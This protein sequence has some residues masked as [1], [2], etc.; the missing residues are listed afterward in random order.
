MIDVG[1]SLSEVC[2]PGRVVLI[3]ELND[4]GVTMVTWN[5]SETLQVWVPALDPSNWTEVKIRTI[6]G[7][8]EGGLTFKEA[9]HHARVFLNQWM[10][11]KC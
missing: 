4:A 2:S 7:N 6:Q 5:Q 11:E 1:N 3:C 9:N 8:R 10:K